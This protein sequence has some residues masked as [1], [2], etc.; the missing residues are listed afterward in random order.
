MDHV[1]RARQEDDAGTG[2]QRRGLLRRAEDIGKIQ[3][4]ET[5]EGLFL[6]KTTIRSEHESQRV[7]ARWNLGE[8]KKTLWRTIRMLTFVQRMLQNKSAD[9]IRTGFRFR[10]AVSNKKTIMPLSSILTHARP[11]SPLLPHNKPTPFAKPE[12]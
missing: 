7:N 8:K 9:E 5:V 12:T 1:V 10:H 11:D 4:W 2:P 3:L 6:L